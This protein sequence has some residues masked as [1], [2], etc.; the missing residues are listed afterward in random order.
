VEPCSS[1]IFVQT[2]I[3]RQLQQ[4]AQHELIKSSTTNLI[5]EIDV[6]QE[7]ATSFEA[8]SSLLGKDEYFFGRE[9]A[10]LFDASVFAYTQLILDEELQWADNELGNILTE[11]GNLVQHRDR[12]LELYY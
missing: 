9:S 8:L 3:C 5:N 6:L 7:A 4:A 2:T 12:M 10:Q 1:N 11:H